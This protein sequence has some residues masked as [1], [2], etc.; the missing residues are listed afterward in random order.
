MVIIIKLPE[1]R[2]RWHVY[3][4]N[5]IDRI[6]IS[7]IW[8]KIIH[9]DTCERE[10]TSGLSTIRT[11]RTKYTNVPHLLISW[12]YCCI[13]ARQKYYTTLLRPRC[14]CVLAIFYIFYRNSCTDVHTTYSIIRGS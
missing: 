14:M 8:Y 5:G 6:I 7:I 9:K 4:L 10:R 2:I 3:I 12:Y 13:A 11:T 1:S